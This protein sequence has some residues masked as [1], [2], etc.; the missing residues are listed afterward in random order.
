M[1]NG[2][3]VLQRDLNT[4]REW[5]QKWKMEFNV[6]K[7]KIMHLGRLNP[8][9]IHNGGREISWSGHGREGSGSMV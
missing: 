7:C 8:G 5:A 3:E 4:I 1:F 2:N 6:D 9:Y